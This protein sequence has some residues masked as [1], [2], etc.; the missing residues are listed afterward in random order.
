M[1]GA[2]DKW[3]EY[4]HPCPA[5]DAFPWAD[6]VWTDNDRVIRTFLSEVCA[7][8]EHESFAECA[9]AADV[10]YVL[11][12][13]H[14]Q[15]GPLHQITAMKEFFSV[16]YGNDPAT[17][18][19]MSQRLTELGTTIWAAGVPDLDSFIVSGML[20]ALSAYP[21]LV[22]GFL[23][24]PQLTSALI[25]SRLATKRDIPSITGGTVFAASSSKPLCVMPNCKSPSSHTW[26]FCRAPGDGMAGKSL[27]D[28][29]NAQRSHNSGNARKQ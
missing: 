6:S 24:T 8:T 23:T 16:K 27:D 12:T 9:T 18:V 26:P 25:K 5:P 21:Q 2:S 11:H 17:F 7:V 1:N 10:W 28:A 29:K 19:T 14:Q 13:R 4:E 20:N 22:D 15:R 3:L